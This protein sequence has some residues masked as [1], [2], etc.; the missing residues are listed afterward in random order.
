MQITPPY[1]IY[2][3]IAIVRCFE[4]LARELELFFSIAYSSLTH[5]RLLS[6]H[7]PVFSFFLLRDLF[8]F[9]AV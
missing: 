1:L 3:T 4:E 5:C 2:D 7:I 9:T 8:I 6:F